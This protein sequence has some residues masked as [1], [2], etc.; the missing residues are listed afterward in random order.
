MTGPYDD[1]INLTH[2]DSLTHS[3]MSMDNRAAQFSPFAA[4]TG[5][6]DAVKETGRLTDERIELDECQKE[7]LNRK[8][9][10][11]IH[12]QTYQTQRI[13]ITYFIPDGKKSGGRYDT[14][15]GYIKKINLYKNS[16]ILTSGL[17]IPV[18]EIIDIE[19]IKC[20]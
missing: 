1:I 7:S 2:P 18:I 16:I 9:Q 20:D 5:Y 15:T 14:V 13:M 19:E 11:I 17:E 4:L 8:L 6:E 3:R 12:K 10:N